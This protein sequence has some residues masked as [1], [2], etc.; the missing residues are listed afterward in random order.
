MVG[1]LREL[2]DSLRSNADRLLRDIQNV[3]SRLVAQI[4]RADTKSGLPAPL[5]RARVA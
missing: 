2:G 4:E 3:H 1:N 5:L